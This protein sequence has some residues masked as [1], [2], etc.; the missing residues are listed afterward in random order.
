[1]KPLRK[2]L[3]WAIAAPLL[4]VLA[5]Q[6]YFL[7]QIWWWRDHNPRSTSFMEQQLDELRKKSPGARLK[8]QWVPYDRISNHL[9][10]AIIAA[11]DAN[12]SEHDGVDW[13]ALQKAYEKNMKKGRVVAGGST[14]TQQLA[15]N[16]FLSGERSYLRKTQEVAITYMLEATMDKERIFE[17]YLNVVEW[18]VGVFGAEAAARHYFG[19]SAAA[20]SPAQAARLAVM[21]PRPRWYDK[22]RG[23]AYLQRRTDLILRRMGGADIP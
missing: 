13:E 4:A 10:R 1:M 21:L 5:I 17:I 14:I 8:H 3:F 16:L 19:V 18:G 6:L 9:K 15:K 2:L 12:F 23:S 20:L 11:E 7:G 22:N